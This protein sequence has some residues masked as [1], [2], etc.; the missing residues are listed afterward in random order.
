MDDLSK[1]PTYNLK[2]VVQETGLK[3][4][5]LRAW[6]RR[7][8]LP[9]PERTA[10]GHRLYSQYDIEMIK[11][12]MERQ[13]EGLRINHAVEMWR[14]FE[15]AGEDP[16]Q[17]MPVEKKPP[18]PG[19]SVDLSGK[20]LEEIKT[21]WVNA[22]M[23]FNEAMAENILAQ[24]FA[25]YPLEAVCL[26][27]LRQGLSD[28]GSMWYAGEA[29]VQQEHFASALAIRRL[30]SMLAAA[31]MPSRRT[32]ILTAC[33]P[34]EDHI[35]PLLMITLFL[36]QRGYDVVYLGANVPLDK[37][38][39]AI[40]TTN[41]DLVISTAQQLHTAGNLFKVAE[42]VQQAGVPLAYG[43]L[44]FNM[45]PSLREHIPG[46][47]LGESLEGVREAVERILK[48]KPEIQEVEGASDHFRKAALEFRDKQP[49]IAASVWE[50]LRPN[51]IQEEHLEMANQFLAKDIEAGL[52][53]GDLT[54]LEHEF[55][56]L[57]DLLLSHNIPVE[58]LPEYLSTYSQV[59][60][61]QLA[62]TG[63]PIVD[64]MDTILRRVKV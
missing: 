4:D 15:A 24:A 39:L 42:Y 54:L 47:F 62:E 52:K 21:D 34:G 59:V 8:G 29:T 61:E 63:Q 10:G 17:A 32:K 3:A 41:P 16:F 18:F 25:R 22:C 5:T 26:E 19:M 2:V 1:T 37:F 50:A 56:W 51:G 33:P 57:S 28:I 9:D 53:F 48:N 23:S 55:E 43:G 60:N 49:L 20:V 6:E 40:N 64:W 7:Y 12:L 14:N 45:V 58:V 44:V 31:P 30:N 36:R 13:N 27:V 46:H 38:D 35:F 11:W